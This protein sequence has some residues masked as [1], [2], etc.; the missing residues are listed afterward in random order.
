MLNRLMDKVLSRVKEETQQ[1][2]INILEGALDLENYRF[3]TGFLNGVDF[4]TNI[5]IEEAKQIY[6]ETVDGE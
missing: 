4:A 2:R 1:N 5:L 6:K 3:Q